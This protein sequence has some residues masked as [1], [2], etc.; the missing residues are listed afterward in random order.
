[1]CEPVQ[2]NQAKLSGLQDFPQFPSILAQINSPYHLPIQTCWL[3][4]FYASKFIILF[5]ITALTG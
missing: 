4:P 1:M 2:K 5:C 3:W